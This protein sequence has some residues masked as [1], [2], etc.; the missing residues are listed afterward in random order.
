MRL[1]AD[2]AVRAV[3]PGGPEIRRTVLMCAIAS[4]AGL[5]IALFAPHDFRLAGAM[6]VTLPWVLQSLWVSYRLGWH[7][8]GTTSVVWRWN[9][10]ALA[11]TV[12]AYLALAMYDLVGA[13]VYAVVQVIAL[14]IVGIA[15]LWSLWLRRRS[16]TVGRAAL[17]FF[18]LAVVV[19][20]VVAYAAFVLV[21]PLSEAAGPEVFF[22]L[23]VIVVAL[24]ML[25]LTIPLVRRVTPGEIYADQ[26][27]AAILVF[28]ILV[29]GGL[30]ILSTGSDEQL[31]V[32]VP[33]W[34]QGVFWAAV[35]G[36]MTVVAYAERARLVTVSVP[37]PRQ[38][39]ALWPYSIALVMPPLAVAAL[40]VDSVEQKVAAVLGFLLVLEVL[41]VRQLV[42]IAERR[43]TR[44]RV[45]NLA[46]RARREADRAGV[47]L[48]VVD[49][50][51][52]STDVPRMCEE[53]VRRLGDVLPSGMGVAAVVAETSP[54]PQGRTVQS[55]PT[56]AATDP[57]H[58]LHGLE[59]AEAL[60]LWSVLARVDDPAELVS[61]D[62]VA[63][64][65]LVP[66][67]I[68]PAAPTGR[69]FPVRTGDGQRV[70]TICLVG[71]GDWDLPQADSDLVAGAAFQLGMGVERASLLHGLERGRDRL[72]NVVEHIPEAVAEIDGADRVL[73]CNEAYATL[74]AVPA[75]DVVGAPA[76][77]EVTARDFDN[78]ELVL[79]E[80]ET[81]ER[82]EVR[83]I[84]LGADAAG[85]S[86][87]LVVLLDVTESREQERRIVDLT[88]ELAEKERSR[89]LLLDRVIT[90]AEA[91]RMR[92]ARQVNEG[93][94]QRLSALCLRLDT[95][96]G[97][98]SAGESGWDHLRLV[99]DLRVDLAEI[100]AGLRSLM[101]TLRP[102]VLDE[103][104]V[105]PALTALTRRLADE[106][107]LRVTTDIG[108]V[109]S[110][111]DSVEN[112]LYRAVQEALSN[113]LIHAH[114]RTLH[115]SLAED[116]GDVVLCV[117]DDGVGVDPSAMH[118][119]RLTSEGHIGLASIIERVELAQGTVEV[120]RGP[121]GGTRVHIRMPRW[122]ARRAGG[123]P[124]PD[125]PTGSV[126]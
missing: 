30:A 58:A 23:F 125:F 16:Q 55:P 59:A 1:H 117:T 15:F 120:A 34:F 94:V 33:P 121:D 13:G 103:R 83:V 68:H 40:L 77:I 90:T 22:S 35:W 116:E 19:S 11:V 8:A 27:F 50:T 67:E 109:G 105:G 49:A 78:G 24:G 39:Q 122:P 92:M 60:R 36:P 6:L 88:R 79:G 10:L 100:I 31:V 37:V 98:A 82:F 124:E 12:P 95:L 111:E 51:T 53:A 41:V 17:G 72:R 44:E 4:G 20:V 97:A 118:L 86:V 85:R 113:V 47:L 89:S 70:G 107:G 112:L 61:P 108:V 75:E 104:G 76:P 74:A 57:V 84:P 56:A 69:A 21:V 5:V 114:A 123:S 52:T 99:S 87:R 45:A 63:L 62:R 106:S 7:L 64:A 28:G 26:V 110:L 46:D 102:P 42:L 2:P 3:L 48:D 126:R 71:R 101:A 96:I 25:G 81:E 29:V 38:G 91:E 80:G 73:V 66:H 119:S 115:V 93:V 65:G 32:F 54:P 9:S 14:P 43:S 18:D